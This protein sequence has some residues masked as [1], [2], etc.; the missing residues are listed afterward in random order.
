MNNINELFKIFSSNEIFTKYLVNINL[1]TDQNELIE[2]IMNDDNFISL[3]CQYVEDKEIIK[4]KVQIK[5]S[6]EIKKLN[7]NKIIDNINDN[8]CEDWNNKYKLRYIS[9][10]ITMQLQNDNSIKLITPNF[11]IYY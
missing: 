6:Q 11:T 5:I 1:E 4:N 10:S 7:K 8:L 3:A 9:D 2:E